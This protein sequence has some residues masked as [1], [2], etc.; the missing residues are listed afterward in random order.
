MEHAIEH[1]KVRERVLLF[2]TELRLQSFSQHGESH[3]VTAGS[4]RAFIELDLAMSKPERP[5]C[6]I[7]DATYVWEKDAGPSDSALS[8]NA[9]VPRPVG[10]GFG[11]RRHNHKSL[12]ALR[13]G[14]ARPGGPSNEVPQEEDADVEAVNNGTRSRS[15]S[16]RRLVVEKLF[17]DDRPAVIESASG[18]SSP[19][20]IT[21]SQRRVS[22]RHVGRASAAHSVYSDDDSSQSSLVALAYASDLLSY[23]AAKEIEE[24]RLGG[25]VCEAMWVTGRAASFNFPDMCAP[26]SRSKEGGEVAK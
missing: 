24:P 19:K 8:S 26:S 20:R 5:S 10:K 11:A 16:R 17:S 7:Q 2:D 6:Y 13:R 12:A 23:D 18:R 4:D 22:Q 14:S 21:R 15:Q 3:D 9:K 1:G 25:S